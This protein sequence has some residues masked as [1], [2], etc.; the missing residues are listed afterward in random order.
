MCHAHC[1]AQFVPRTG[2]VPQALGPRLGPRLGGAKSSGRG[3]GD[4]R[5]PGALAC[6]NLRRPARP[7]DPAPEGAPRRGFSEET[8][9][10][11]R[12]ARGERGGGREAARAGAEH[13][14]LPPQMQMH[15]HLRLHSGLARTCFS[16]SQ[17]RRTR[18][19]VRTDGANPVCICICICSLCIQ[20]IC[21][22][23]PPTAP[24]RL[25]GGF[26]SARPPGAP[27]R[28][29]AAAGERAR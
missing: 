19:Y 25:G 13:S 14:A 4:R 2:P 29:A 16:G 6:E 12:P 3:R 15:L 18:T 11:P 10:P 1:A 9:L 28:A 7:P 27:A 20:H 23:T 17:T 8:F 21:I 5:A 26:E 24:R 22:S